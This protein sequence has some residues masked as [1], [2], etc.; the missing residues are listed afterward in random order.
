MLKQALREV[1]EQ[2]WQFE[3]RDKVAS[4]AFFP[5]VQLGYDYISKGNKIAWFDSPRPF[6]IISK[7][8][9]VLVAKKYE[10]LLSRGPLRG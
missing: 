9:R 5:I 8:E 3:N 6:E 10:I 7:S 1:K 2:E 4:V